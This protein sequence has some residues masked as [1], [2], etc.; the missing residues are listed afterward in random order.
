M[1][2]NEYEE[3]RVNGEFIKMKSESTNQ[4]ESLVRSKYF[5]EVKV[6]K[7]QIIVFGIHQQDIRIDK[8]IHRK[9]YLSIGIVVLMKNQSTGGLNLVCMRDFVVER[10]V[11]L[12]VELEPGE[13]IIMP[14]T[15]GCGI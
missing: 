7:K 8:V 4:Y 3:V 1:R 6:Q 11:E 13:Y 15:S 9:P 10:Q 2:V 5:Y 12:E 14:R